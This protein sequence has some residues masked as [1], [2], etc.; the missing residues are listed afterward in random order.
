MDEIKGIA[1][2]KF[3]PGKVEEWKRLT[4][5]AMKIVRT[6]DSGTLQYEIFFNEDESEAI[7]FERYRDPEAALEHFSNISHLMAPLMATASVTGEVLGT[8]NAKMK[9]LLG[10]GEPKLFTPWMA[11]Q[12]R[13]ESE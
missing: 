5:E 3:H 7:V 12:D 11:L 1:R 8:P 9:Q 13:S 4:E 10:K 6:K 2:V